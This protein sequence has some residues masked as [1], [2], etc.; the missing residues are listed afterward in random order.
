M[1]TPTRIML[2]G[3]DEEVKNRVTR[4]NRFHNRLCFIRV[5]FRDE[6]GRQLANLPHIS[7]HDIHKRY[8]EVTNCGLLIAGKHYTYLGFSQATLREH[9]AWFVE[10]TAEV[11]YATVIN[12]LGSL[13]DIRSPRL[14]AAQIGQALTETPAMF[15]LKN[16]E[17]LWKPEEDSTTDQHFYNYHT[18]IGTISPSAYTTIKR[19]LGRHYH[20]GFLQIIWGGAKGMLSVAHNPPRSMKNRR[21]LRLI[22]IRNSMAAFDSSKEK[23]LEICNVIN[24]PS[25]MCLDRPVCRD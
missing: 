5:R 15:I 19:H 18:N 17:I 9:S 24:L 25:P 14:C 22:T 7:H 8:G 6:D 10:N 13:Q 21:N 16:S 4:R 1:V 12:S 3:P 11:N 2:G 20:L 23:Q